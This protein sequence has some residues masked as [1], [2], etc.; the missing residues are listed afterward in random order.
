MIY[1]VYAYIRKSDGTPYYIGK[2]KDK[3][4]YCKHKGVSVPHDKSKI[5]F[6]E[7]CLTEVGAFALERRY[8]AWWGRK[9]LGTGIL[10]NQTAGGEGH[11][12][13]SATTR[14]KIGAAQKGKTISVESKAKQRAKMQGRSPS[15]EHRDKLSDALRGRSTG[16]MSTEQKEVRRVASLLAW[17]KKKAK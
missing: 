12:N 9:D 7:T 1:Y 4:A 17:A 15:Q 14:S 2:G 6:L 8:I 3:R 11:G 13:P 16:P 5:V 10:L